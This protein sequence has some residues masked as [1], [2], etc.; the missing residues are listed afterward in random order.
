[1]RSLFVALAGLTLATAAAAQNAPAA[2]A[3]GGGAIVTPNSGQ[4]DGPGSPTGSGIGATD[5]AVLPNVGG[6]GPGGNGFGNNTSLNGASST[7]A[8]GGSTGGAPAN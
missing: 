4:L 6:N 8:P 1:M 2:P 3:G 5:G 7:G